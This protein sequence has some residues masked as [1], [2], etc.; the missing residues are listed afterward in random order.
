M[1]EPFRGHLR[2]PTATWRT[3]CERVG[4]FPHRSPIRQQADVLAPG[5]DAQLAM[6][7]S[8]DVEALHLAAFAPF[9][10]QLEELDGAAAV[11]LAREALALFHLALVVV[12]AG[13]ALLQKAADVQRLLLDRRDPLGFRLD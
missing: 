1:S 4:H 11:L 13:R 7:L 10:D 6:R 9:A 2:L 8:A 3:A 12:V 5:I